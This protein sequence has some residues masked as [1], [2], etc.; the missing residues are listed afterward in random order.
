LFHIVLASLYV[1][2]A[3]LGYAA[4]RSLRQGILPHFENQDPEKRKT[5]G[6]VYLGPMRVNEWK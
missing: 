1:D 4:G 3:R 6:I 5:A 2:V